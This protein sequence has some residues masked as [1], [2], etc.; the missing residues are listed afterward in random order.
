MENFMTTGKVPL[1]LCWAFLAFDT[2]YCLYL[3][4]DKTQFGDKDFDPAQAEPMEEAAAVKGGGGGGGG[5]GKVVAVQMRGLS[6]TYTGLKDTRGKKAPDVCALGDLSLDCFENEVT[7]LLGQ[8]GA[9]KTTAFG[10]L[11]GTLPP[12]SGRAS[13]FGYDL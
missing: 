3:A 9:G 10:V 13:I 6:K 1:W 8:N 11:T 5:G 4:R 12:S 2:V 7:A